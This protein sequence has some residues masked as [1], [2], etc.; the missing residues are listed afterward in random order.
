MQNLTISSRAMTRTAI[1]PNETP[2]PADKAV[3]SK[4]SMPPVR[5]GQIA[6]P[7]EHGGWGLLFEPL[8]AGLAI[9]P[10]VGG[11]CIAV[12]TVGAF[13]TRQPLKMLVIDRLGMRID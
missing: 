3:R 2:K 10:S 11:L 6:L 5:V 1:D 13:L 8:V 7:S 12:M 9:A 4:S